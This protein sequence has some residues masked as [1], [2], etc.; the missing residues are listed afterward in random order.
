MEQKENL[1]SKFQRVTLKTCKPSES[2][3]SLTDNMLLG[4]PLARTTLALAAALATAAPSGTLATPVHRPLTHVAAG[5]PDTRLG[6]ERS[7][8]NVIVDLDKPA[9]YRWAGV[10][11]AAVAEHGWEHTYAPVAAYLK[12]TIP[13]PVLKLVEDIA[14][15]LEEHGI[16]AEYGVLTNPCPLST[17]HRPTRS[18]LRS[19]PS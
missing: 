9:E 4:A 12:E 7:I 6:T 1:A 13:A 15:A 8:P 2:S 17:T 11:L 10:M 18:S 14:G 19:D 16:P 3:K 5:N